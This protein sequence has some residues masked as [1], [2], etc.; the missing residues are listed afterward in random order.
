MEVSL[1]F[2][3]LSKLLLLDF[4]QLKLVL[5]LFFY[6]GAILFYFDMNFWYATNSSQFSDID[7]CRSVLEVGPCIIH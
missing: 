4:Y 6:L 3:W 5:F 2:N 1:L 7:K